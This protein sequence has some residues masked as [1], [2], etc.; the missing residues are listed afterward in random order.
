MTLPPRKDPTPR[1]AASGRTRLFGILAIA[2]LVLAIILLALG[3]VDF[4]QQGW[5]Q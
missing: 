1:S 2:G 5:F 3:L 4:E